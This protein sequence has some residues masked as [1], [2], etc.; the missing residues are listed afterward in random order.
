MLNHLLSFTTIENLLFLTCYSLSN[1]DNIR[2]KQLLSSKVEYLV[3]QI[4]FYLH[5]CLSY[6]SLLSY[7]P[8]L[9]YFNFLLNKVLTL[10]Y[11][12]IF[13]YLKATKKLLK[14]MSV[15]F[16]LTCSFKVIHICCSIL[17]KLCKQGFAH[18]F[19]DIYKQTGE[20]HNTDQHPIKTKY[21]QLYWILQY[22][23]QLSVI[24]GVLQKKLFLKIS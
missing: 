10:K 19:L 11:L 16:C 23:C 8:N 18:S 17:F 5:I 12:Y 15:S 1:I 6:Y 9:N 20:K 22:M 3:R 14:F 4:Q 21:I 24:R 7:T 2:L 13:F